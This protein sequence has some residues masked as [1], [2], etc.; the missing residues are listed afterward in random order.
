MAIVYTDEETEGF[1]VSWERI[2]NRGVLYNMGEKVLKRRLKLGQAIDV[3]R[4]TECDARWCRAERLKK[5][6]SKEEVGAGD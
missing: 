2:G 4:H 5:V 6:S 1:L 3:T